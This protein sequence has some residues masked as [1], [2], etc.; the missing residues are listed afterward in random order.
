MINQQ[1]PLEF[2]NA[3]LFYFKDSWGEVEGYLPFICS[4]FEQNINTIIIYFQQYPG[5]NNPES[6]IELFDYLKKNSHYIFF[7]KKNS[8]LIKNFRRLIEHIFLYRIY[9]LKI[10]IFISNIMV[11]ANKNLLKKTIKSN[12]LIVTKLFKD[13]VNDSIEL[14]SIQSTLKPNEIIVYPH[15][16]MLRTHVSKPERRIRSKYDMVLIGSETDKVYFKSQGYDMDK[17]HVVGHPKYDL[18]WISRIESNYLNF[19]SI[20]RDDYS[21]II[22]IYTRNCGNSVLDCS[23]YNYILTSAIKVSLEIVDSFVIIKPHPREDIDLI[24]SLIFSSFDVDRVKVVDIPSQVLA[25]NSDIIIS[26]W[27]SSISDGILFNKIV[28]QFFLFNGRNP[29]FLK[30]Q[31]G[32]YGSIYEK[33]GIILAVR[34]ERELREILGQL[35]NI[36]PLSN[37]HNPIYLANQSPLSKWLEILG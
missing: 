9:N 2:K 13:H 14:I 10:S 17:L 19:F 20:I 22:T 29:Q 32:K 26:M 31:N 16:T 33:L 34:S 12:K 36:Y 4:C 11:F 30:L 35:Q 6:N 23:D 5:I 8:Y 28:I 21:K 24:K 25:K 15:G 27:S 7:D 18:S 37:N 1:K 3:Y